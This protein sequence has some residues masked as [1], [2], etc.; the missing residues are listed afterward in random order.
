M[1]GQTP[2]EHNIEKIIAAKERILKRTKGINNNTLCV[3]VCVCVA[4]LVGG[5][6]EMQG[7]HQIE[8]EGRVGWKKAFEFDSC[9]CL[10]PGLY[11]SQQESWTVTSWWH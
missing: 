5:Y 8:A 9:S 4:L 3:C 6:W 1:I 10:T 7:R 11:W 2:K